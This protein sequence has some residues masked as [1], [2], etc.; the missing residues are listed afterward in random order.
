M[1][2]IAPDLN[3]IQICYL[4][5][6]PVEV[7]SAILPAKTHFSPFIKANIHLHARAQNARSAD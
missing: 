2:H 7:A 3:K 6:V 4:D 5:G 1:K